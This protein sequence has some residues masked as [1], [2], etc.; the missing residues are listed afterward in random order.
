MWGYGL[1]PHHY[2]KMHEE[3]QAHTAA[4]TA[5]REAKV[6]SE[7]AKNPSLQSFTPG[8]AKKGAGLFKVGILFIIDMQQKL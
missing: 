7:P 4:R 8:D 5:R 1:L 3:D 2:E 6:A